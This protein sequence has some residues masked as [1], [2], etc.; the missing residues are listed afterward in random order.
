VVTETTDFH[1]QQ[2]NEGDRVLVLYGAAN[3]DPELF[4]DPEEVTLTR[5]SNR[6]IAF[7]YGIHRCLGMHLARTELIVALRHILELM[8]HYRLAAPDHIE[9]GY[10][11]ARGIRSVAVEVAAAGEFA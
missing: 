1:G 9:W 11:E 10:G 6:H 8:P 4:E 3:R 7:G 5:I 2:F